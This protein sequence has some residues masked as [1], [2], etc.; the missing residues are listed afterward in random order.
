L[1]AAFFAAGTLGADARSNGPSL[2]ESGRVP[3]DDWNSPGPPSKVCDGPS[4]SL[5]KVYESRT[6]C[7]KA[8]RDKLTVPTDAAITVYGLGGNDTII[9]KGPV[10]ID[11]GSGNDRADVTSARLASCSADTEKV[12][13]AR[14]RRLKCRGQS[15]ARATDVDPP[16]VDFPQVRPVAPSVR[17]GIY[18]NGTWYVRLAE[19]PLL[20]AFNTIP[21]KVEFQ[22]VAIGVRLYKWDAAKATWASFRSPVWLW[23]DT[24][25]LDWPR[26]LNYWR[27]FDTLKRFKVSWN[28][29]SSDAGYY[30]VMIAYHWYPT[31]QSGLT[32]TINVPAFD[33]RY[34][35]EDH[36]HF[37]N[38]KTT[39][40]PK[41]RY[42]A[43]G[44][45]ADGGP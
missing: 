23:D 43:F 3:L 44:V 38:D 40:F 26:D 19:E 30:R 20:R 12:Y 31:V 33:A 28:L 36:F 32:A 5:V 37:G 39:G 4:K 29:T 24:H 2:V 16:K 15:F 45:P 35:V 9:A 10:N 13:D 17:C 6:M 25:D 14:N 21:G 27:T 7:G 8:G 42:C 18:T 41:D 1:A 22:K 34:W 11:G